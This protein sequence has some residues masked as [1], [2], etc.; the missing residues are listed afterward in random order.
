MAVQTATER[1][2]EHINRLQ[3]VRIDVDDFYVIFRCVD[4]RQA[5]DLA[6]G[7][8]LMLCEDYRRDTSILLGQMD[9]E[10]VVRHTMRDFTEGLAESV[11]RQ[12]ER[13]SDRSSE[14]QQ[15]EPLIQTERLRIA[16]DMI[17]LAE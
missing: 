6:A 2:V 17:G 8:A 10:A 16:D 4:N 3:Q 15:A 1:V 5:E 12:R 11:A 7:M 9:G 13:E 14:P